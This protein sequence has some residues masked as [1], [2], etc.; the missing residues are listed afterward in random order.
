MALRVYRRHSKACKYAGASDSNRNENRCRCK[1]WFDW[2]IDGK[3]ITKP[4]DTRDWQKALKDARRIETEGNAEI[5]ISPTIHDGCERFLASAFKREL[6]ESSLNKYRLLI[7]Q[8]EAFAGSKGIVYFSN[9]NL[10]NVREF[11]ETWKNRGQAARKKIEY[12]R[13]LLGFAQEAGWIPENYAKKI[14]FPIITAPPVMPFFQEDIDK[15][16]AAIPLYPEHMNNRVRLNALILLLWHSGLRIGDAVTLDRQKIS[17]GSIFLRTEKTGTDVFIPLPPQVLTA[18]KSCPSPYPFWTGKSKRKSCIGDWQRALKRLFKLAKVE[19]GHPHR[20]RHGAAV[21]WLLAG[22][23]MEQVAALLGHSDIQI[24]QRVYAQWDRKRQD[25][26]QDAI[27]RTWTTRE[28][29][30]THRYKNATLS[31]QH[32]L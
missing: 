21:R 23:S 27:K 22:L 14:D 18:L 6:K 16:L 5:R 1:I 4:L 32:Q 24:T 26:L 20:F 29:R 30:K 15:M 31:K 13:R 10:D 11:H 2:H 7:R 28:T 3:R 17:N 25:Q 19:G 9:L 12:F 8:L